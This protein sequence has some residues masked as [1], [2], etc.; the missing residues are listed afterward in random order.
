MDWLALGA[1]V[2]RWERLTRLLL[3]EYA[4]R[5]EL[6]GRRTRWAQLADARAALE[7]GEMQ[8]Q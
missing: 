2:Q 1:V 4:A 3:E 7:R 8:L 5:P 6:W